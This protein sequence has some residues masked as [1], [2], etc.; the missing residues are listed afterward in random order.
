VECQIFNLPGSIFADREL[1]KLLINVKR[2]SRKI[3]ET[4]FNCQLT[5]QILNLTCKL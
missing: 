3:L 2:Y 1:N 5:N 4:V